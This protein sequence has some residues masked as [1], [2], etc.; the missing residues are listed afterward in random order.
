MF[1]QALLI[2]NLRVTNAVLSLMHI[3]LKT[4]ETGFS[5]TS[6]SISFKTTAAGASYF[7]WA[8]FNQEGNY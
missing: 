5:E 7:V 6:Y 1:L 4:K 2:L 8:S 3:L